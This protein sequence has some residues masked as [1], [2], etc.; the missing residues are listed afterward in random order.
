[1]SAPMGIPRINNGCYAIS[2]I[3]CLRRLFGHN[4]SYDPDILLPQLTGELE[5]AHEY[6]VRL[7]EILPMHIRQELRIE[8][9]NKDARYPSF[10]AP[11]LIMDD[12][13]SNVDGGVLAHGNV[14]AVK[15][16]VQYADINDC[17]KLVFNNP[18]E[19][20]R[21]R[22]FVCMEGA[23]YYSIVSSKDQSVWYY[24]DDNNVSP[25]TGYVFP[26]CMIFYA[27]YRFP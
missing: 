27:S 4:K 1:M 18:E 2:I 19:T 26:I 24:C 17:M 5:D 22:A 3:Q 23:H 12:K 10:F 16:P 7:F 8:L 14:V 21:A 11:S 9:Q 15:I 6:Y 25:V 13:H 20:Y